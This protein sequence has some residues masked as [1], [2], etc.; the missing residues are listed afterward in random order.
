MLPGERE[1][2]YPYVAQ[3]TTH[4][5]CAVPTFIIDLGTRR[6]WTKDRTALFWQHIS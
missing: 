5:R 2:L 4:A 6:Y 1:L 3:T